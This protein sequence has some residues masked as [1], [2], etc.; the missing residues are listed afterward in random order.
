MI[1]CS[2]R[3]FCLRRTCQKTDGLL[4]VDADQVSVLSH[5]VTFCVLPSLD[6]FGLKVIAV[7]V[8]EQ[9]AF[10]TV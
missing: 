7:F 5:T 2:K 1:N 9:I 3:S 6:C 4:V 8:E 10:I